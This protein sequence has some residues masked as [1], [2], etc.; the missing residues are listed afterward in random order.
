M[1]GGL[2]ACGSATVVSQNHRPKP[3]EEH[4]ASFFLTS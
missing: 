2:S 4:F 1:I 3:M